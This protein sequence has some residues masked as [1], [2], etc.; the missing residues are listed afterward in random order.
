MYTFYCRGGSI[1]SRR[2]RCQ[3]S[4]T[5]RSSLDHFPE[6]H[7]AGSPAAAGGLKAGDRLLTLDGRWTDSLSDAFIAASFVKPGSP[8]VLTVKRDG[9]EVKLTVKPAKGT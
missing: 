3:R 5:S 7:I 4:L 2:G 9:K 6:S 8:A 1:P